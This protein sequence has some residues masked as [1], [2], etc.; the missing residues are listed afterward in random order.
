MNSI[1][2]QLHIIQPTNYVFIEET[3]SIIAF[4]CFYQTI[5]RKLLKLLVS[6]IDAQLFQR[7][8]LEAFCKVD[9]FQN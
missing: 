6:K 3:I 7:I 5:H 1:A 8:V 2:F 9:E 4:P